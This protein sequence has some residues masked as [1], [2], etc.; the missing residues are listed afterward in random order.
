M[1][2]INLYAY[3]FQGPLSRETGVITNNFASH[4]HPR[5]RGMIMISITY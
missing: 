5:R 1:P 4:S 2:K 3:D